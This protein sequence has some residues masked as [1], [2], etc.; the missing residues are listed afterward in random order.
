M[1]YILPVAL[2]AALTACA[3]PVS[4][5]PKIGKDEI[6]AEARTQ[7]AMVKQGYT[8]DDLDVRTQSMAERRKR[9]TRVLK[10][11]TKE[12]VKL[13]G[14]FIEA[15]GNCIYPA[16]INEDSKEINAFADGERIHVNTAIMDFVRNDDE[17]AAVIGHEYAHNLMGHIDGG[18]RNA[19]IGGLLGM[20]ADLLMASQGI[21]SN[22]EFTKAGANGG[23]L[24][25]AAD[26][27]READ[28][29]GSY[30]MYRAGYKLE[31][32]PAFWRRMSMEHPD[33]IYIGSTHPVNPERY[34]MMQ[35]TAAEIREKKAAG[36][37]L[38]PDMKPRS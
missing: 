17:L 27:E 34:I 12:G 19:A 7:E 18:N 14:Q 35:K 13:C 30:L 16:D 21:N 33:S 6:S 9:L 5:T 37:P 2:L 24:S 3:T 28:Y 1:R 25:Y 36:E 20:A 4:Q 26:F 15:K 10:R 8:I 38:V 22:G 11:I 29:V 32:A 23:R 31:N